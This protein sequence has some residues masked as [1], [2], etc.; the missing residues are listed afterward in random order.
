MSLL[1][2]NLQQQRLIICLGSGGVGKTTTAAALAWAGSGARRRTAVITVD[3]A[4]RLKDSL[5]LADLSVEPQPVPVGGRGASLDALAVDTKR[6]F[7]ALIKRV[8]SGFPHEAV[9]F[10][11]IA[12]SPA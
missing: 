9:R 6:V 1:P 10:S 7:D 11:N 5:G 3:P 4:P 8:K 12:V 2:E